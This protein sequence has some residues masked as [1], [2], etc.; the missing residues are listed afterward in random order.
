M[1]TMG[2]SSA[3]YM[4]LSGRTGNQ[5]IGIFQNLSKE[6]NEMQ[7]NIWTGNRNCMH[8]SSHVKSQT[9]AD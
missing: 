8:V 9:C 4:N 5:L 6:N 3:L 2:S 1:L 7:I